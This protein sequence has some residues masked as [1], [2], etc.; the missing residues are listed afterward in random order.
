MVLLQTKYEKRSFGLTTAIF[1]VIFVW[2]FFYMLKDDP[3][4][5]AVYDTGE[6]AINF[7]TSNVGQGKVQPME[8]IKS[9]PTSA[10]A[11]AAQS[12]AQ[13]LTTQNTKAA[14]VIN[15]S[16]SKSTSTSTTPVKPKAAEAPKPAKSTTDALSSILNGP[17]SD[18]RAQGGEGNDNVGGDKGS[19]S[20][21][22][23]ASSY[24]G[25]GKG[26]GGWGLNG[27]K[28]S[29]TGKVVQQCNQSG[30]V[31]V[32]ITVNRSGNVIAANYS[33]GTTNTDPCLVQPAIATAKKYKWQPDANAPETQIGFIVVNF[34]LGE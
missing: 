10:P 12:A 29:T 6:I 19:V 20:G 16:E 8:P 14:P 30:T 24:F 25:S 31:V 9:A 28:L 32:Q 13:N 18:G 23:Y 15:T 7:G 27:R 4:I 21:D 33:K 1:V 17:Q 26:G 34:T 2:C 22:P 11:E 5:P 3:N